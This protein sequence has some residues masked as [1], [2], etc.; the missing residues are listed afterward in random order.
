MQWIL[1]V[2]G[3]IFFKLPGAILGFIIGYLFKNT[4]IKTGG[5]LGNIFQNNQQQTVSPADFE[6]NLLSLC[7]LVIKANGQVSQS[8]LDFVRMRFVEMYGKE[9]AN[10][11]FRTFNELVK[12]REISAYRVS[13]YLKIRT[14]YET[15]LQI[16]HFLFGIAKADGIVSDSEIKQIQEISGYFGISPND[17][18]SI[19][20]MFVHSQ[21]E[22]IRDA[23][24]ILEINKNAT[25]AEVKKAYREMAKKYHPDRV[26]T[27]DEAIKKGAE[28]KFKQVQKAYEQIQKERGL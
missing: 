28:E 26:I 23:Y 15:R 5:S 6:V 11:V 14:P 2:L 8:E 9:R 21:T 17:F 16:I 25:D 1:A 4:T 10:A 12:G 19:K 18:E 7:S 24:T 27:Q 22:S 3:F 20:A 13:T